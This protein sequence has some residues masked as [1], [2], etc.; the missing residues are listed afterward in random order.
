MTCRI[1]ISSLNHSKE[2][3][4]AAHIYAATGKPLAPDVSLRAVAQAAAGLSGAELAAVLDAA[5]L[6]A[7]VRGDV[8]ID[9]ED[10]GVALD[11]ALLD[12]KWG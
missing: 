3:V 4:A 2:T 9:A 12:A 7:A 5:A 8:V 11:E 6:A 10:V 1:R